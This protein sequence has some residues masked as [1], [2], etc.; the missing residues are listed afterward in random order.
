MSMCCYFLQNGATA[1]AGVARLSR[2]ASMPLYDRQGNVQAGDMA[3]SAHWPAANAQI[4]A[5]RVRNRPHSLPILLACMK[6][7]TPKLVTKISSPK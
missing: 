5:S 3:V 6:P 2:G 1:A 7:F 4:P